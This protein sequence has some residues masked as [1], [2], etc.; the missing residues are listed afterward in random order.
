MFWNL[1]SKLACLVCSCWK[2]IYSEEATNFLQNLLRR[3]VL[4]RNGQLYGGD[5]A[6]F[7]GLLKIYELQIKSDFRKSDLFNI[8]FL[9][10]ILGTV[11]FNTWLILSWTTD[12]MTLIFT[13]SDNI[14]H[15]VWKIDVILC[16]CS[17]TNN[18]FFSSQLEISRMLNGTTSEIQHSATMTYIVRRY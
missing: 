7:C 18:I 11:P 4:C 15:I 8:H 6:K 13:Q 10:W 14:D 1:V 12:K 16:I 2:F 5:F 17:A 9:C 3:F